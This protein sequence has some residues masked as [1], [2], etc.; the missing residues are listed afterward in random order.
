MPKKLCDIGIN[1]EKEFNLIAESCCKTNVSGTIGN[2]VRLS[3]EDI[4]KILQK[5]T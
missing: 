3:K 4:V 5:C 1:S 2:L